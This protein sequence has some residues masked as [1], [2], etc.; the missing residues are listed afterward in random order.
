MR[1]AYVMMLFLVFGCAE[2]SSKGENSGP[3][4]ASTNN[5]P[6]NASN[7]P[8]TNSENSLPSGEW[9]WTPI[10]GSVCGK[11]TQAGIGIADG[12]DRT[13]LVIHFEGGGACWDATSCHVLNGAVNIE[14][15]YGESNFQTTIQSL[16]DHK[17][18]NRVTGPFGDVPTVYVP[19]CTGDLHAGDHVGSYDAFNPNRL[20]HHKGGAN[21]ELFLAHLKTLYPN[22]EEIFVVGISAGGYGAMMNH[23]RFRSAFPGVPVHVLADGSPLVQP[24]DGRWSAWKNAWRFEMPPGC[25]DCEDAYRAFAQNAIASDAGR[26]AL[27]TYL[28][29]AVIALYFAYQSGLGLAVTSLLDDVYTGDWGENGSAFYKEGTDHVM[30]QHYESL[31]DD[32]SRRLEDFVRAWAGE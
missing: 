22:L 25:I 12:V 31:E 3:N 27:L 18:F 26:I 17:L 4:N 2:E 23:H 21:V 24:R 28:D 32:E 15:D 19:Y 8:N 16:A 10:E 7:N 1:A 6:N 5:I 20:V 30:L 11:G 29:D 9:V 13:R 14:S